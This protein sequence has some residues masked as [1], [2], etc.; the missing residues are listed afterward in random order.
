MTRARQS[1]LSL[2]RKHPTITFPSR[3][4]PSRSLSRALHDRCRAIARGIALAF[5]PG[6]CLDFPF[7]DL[8][9]ALNHGP[10][11][12][13]VRCKTIEAGGE[14][15][16]V[17][18]PCRRL[19]LTWQGSEGEMFSAPGEHL[20]KLYR[21]G[22]GPSP[23]ALT[24]VLRHRNTMG[25]HAPL[26]A[27][28]LG[29]VA[30]LGGQARRG[31]AI[32]RLPRR[33]WPLHALIDSPVE[34]GTARGWDTPA[35]PLLL[36]VARSLAEA[37]G[38]LHDAGFVHGDLNYGNVL[39][40]IRSGAVHLVDLDGVAPPGKFHPGSKGRWGFAAP[41]VVLG[42]APDMAAERHALALTIA[43]T[44]LLRNV[45]LAQ[46][47]L[48]PD[49]QQRDDAAAYGHAAC[50]SEH[51]TDTRNR[52]PLLGMPVFHGGALS[53]SELPSRVRRLM[54]RAFMDGLQRPK[55]RPSAGE[56]AQALEWAYDHLVPCTG[57]GQTMFDDPL[58]SRCPFCGM[59]T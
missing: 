55:L 44:L 54:E 47:I 45:M 9:R 27:W 40:D 15:G 10:R 46:T 16:S 33:L 7:P 1:P 50:F 8:V 35:W 4:S 43:W 5:R 38:L 30:E 41:E 21:P 52:P 2:R 34:F 59:M 56:W 23:E 3:P 28:P 49:H 53:W 24:E 11:G 19:P 37:V 22:R 14:A 18:L 17:T 29:A 31:V 6:E 36:T 48:N 58:P 13:I 42:A 12:G 39:A 25:T 26:R 32:P 20:V 51:P 57:C